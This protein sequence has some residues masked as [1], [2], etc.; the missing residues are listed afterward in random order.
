ME[1]INNIIEYFSANPLKILFVIAGSGGI[2]YWWKLYRSRPKLKVRLLSEE[3]NSIDL[4]NMEV[5]S[6]FEV[7]NIGGSS[8][9]LEP[10]VLFTG[11]TP[12]KER[13]CISQSFIENDRSLP[14][15]TSKQFTLISKEG[16]KYPYL[17]FRTYLF[18]LTRGNNK[19]LR[20]LSADKEHIGN[21]R[22]F[23]GLA[24]FK[25]LNIMPD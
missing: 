16:D 10:N 8:T 14:P 21:F 17:H 15:F 22:H 2:V 6:I 19:R 9:S 7:E 4:T 3:Y 25:M 5:K 24:L 11:Y 13:R 20:I 12:K 18:R 23:I 1:Y